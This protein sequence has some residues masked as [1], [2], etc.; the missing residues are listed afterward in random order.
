MEPGIA[1]YVFSGLWGIAMVAVLIS[2]IRLC[3]R[4][5]ERSERLRNRTGLPM[6]AM[7]PQVIANRGVARDAETQALRRRANLRFLIIF[8]GFALFGLITSFIGPG[9]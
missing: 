8:A 6:Y 2:A 9:G 4:V 3:Y 5:E 1:F 7:W